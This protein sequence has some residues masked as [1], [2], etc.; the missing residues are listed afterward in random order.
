ME[1]IQQIVRSIAIIE[2]ILGV[3]IILFAIC[4]LIKIE[5]EEA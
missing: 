2:T 3:V 4:K 5:K 1:I